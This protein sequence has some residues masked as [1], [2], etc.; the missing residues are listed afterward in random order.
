MSNTSF[1]Y[2]NLSLCLVLHIVTVKKKKIVSFFF[3][4]RQVP[5]L[6]LCCR[7]GRMIFLLPGSWGLRSMTLCRSQQHCYRE[8]LPFFWML[9][10]CCVKITF[11]SKDPTLSKTNPNFHFMLHF[12]HLNAC[13]MPWSDGVWHPVRSWWTL[14]MGS[15]VRSILTHI[16]KLNTDSGHLASIHAHLGID[17]DILILK[18]EVFI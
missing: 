9:M 14:S 18:E 5:F 6:S 11:I 4:P 8:A 3:L 16:T 13:V 7:V 17:A 15:D 1:S 12:H 10:V 2:G